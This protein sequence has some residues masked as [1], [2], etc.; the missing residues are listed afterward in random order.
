MTTVLVDRA[1]LRTALA[2]LL[3]AELVGAGKPVNAVYPYHVADIKGKAPVVFVTSAGSF[4]RNPE[5]SARNTSL[6]YLDVNVFV[7]YS[8]SAVGWTEEHSE[9]RLD[10]IEKSIGEIVDNNSENPKLPWMNL[11]FA[12]RSEI[13]PAIIGGEDYDWEIIPLVAELW[14]A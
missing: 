13:R 14:G 1:T 11:D 7:V 2:T 8:D 12:G 5:R 3:A 9:A 6:A 4:R 10:L